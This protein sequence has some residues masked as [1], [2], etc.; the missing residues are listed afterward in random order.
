MSQLA[1]LDPSR[2]EVGKLELRLGSSSAKI[3]QSV[4]RN[5]GEMAPKL[6]GNS[7]G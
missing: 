7:P 2:R 1:K 3:P 4:L 5:L 6:T